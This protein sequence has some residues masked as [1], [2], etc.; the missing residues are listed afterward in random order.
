MMYTKPYSIY[1]RGTISSGFPD[2]QHL[3]A[4]RRNG[5][6]INVV[7]DSFALLPFITP[8]RPSKKSKDL[9]P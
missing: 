9:I 5:H 7:Q 6:K 1:L 8:P 2:S 3:K 4:W